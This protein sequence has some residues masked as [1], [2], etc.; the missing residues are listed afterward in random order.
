MPDL[1]IAKNPVPSNIVGYYGISG[2]T[3]EDVTNQVAAHLAVFNT[4]SNSVAESSSSTNSDTSVNA[5]SVTEG[6]IIVNLLITYP[7]S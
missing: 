7:S 3:G 6:S 5:V 4:W 1:T 2:V